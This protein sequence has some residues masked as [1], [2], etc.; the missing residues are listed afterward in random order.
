VSAN[1]LFKDEYGDW[2]GGWVF[3][4]IIF[5][6]IAGIVALSMPFAITQAKYKARAY[7][8]STGVPMTTA[9]AFWASPMIV[10]VPKGVTTVVIEKGE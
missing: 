8:A 10:A 3:A 7:T 6:I 1:R 5:S 4:L 2:H 9:E